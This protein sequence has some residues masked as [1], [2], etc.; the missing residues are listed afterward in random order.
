M[1]FPKT[2]GT[3]YVLSCISSGTITLFCVNKQKKN[4]QLFRNEMS[5][6][7]KRQTKIAADDILIF[8]LLSVKEN[9]A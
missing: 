9:K 3:V 7:L 4:K 8:L 6:P 5:L 2:D 1:I